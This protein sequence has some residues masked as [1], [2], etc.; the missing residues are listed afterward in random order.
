VAVHRALDLAP[1]DVHCMVRAGHVYFHLGDRE[2]CLH[3]FREARRAGF[4]AQELRRSPDLAS[5][6]EDPEFV[7]IVEEAP[8]ASDAPDQSVPGKQASRADAA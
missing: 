4:G 1:R 8:A 5:L 3:W 6:R 2:R 7:R